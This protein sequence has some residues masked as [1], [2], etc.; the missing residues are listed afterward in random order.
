MLI[1]QSG[2]NVYGLSDDK[3]SLTQ[4]PLQYD[5]YP[6]NPTPESMNAGI[7]WYLDFL[8]RHKPHFTILIHEE[9][10]AGSTSQTAAIVYIDTM[11]GNTLK[12]QIAIYTICNAITT[13]KEEDLERSLLADQELR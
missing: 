5:K 12:K 2:T 9:E 3:Q 7:N 8:A 4:L 1:I 13:D 6:T 10:G 11:Q